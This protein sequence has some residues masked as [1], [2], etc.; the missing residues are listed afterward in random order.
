VVRRPKSPS[1]SGILRFN[2]VKYLI[3]ERGPSPKMPFAQRVPSLE[4]SQVLD[5]RTWSVAL[6]ALRLAGSFAYGSI[7]EKFGAPS[8]PGLIWPATATTGGHVDAKIP[9]N[10]R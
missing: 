9:G 8:E 3:S 5:K 6:K 2:A 7:R 10:R 1:L 4:C